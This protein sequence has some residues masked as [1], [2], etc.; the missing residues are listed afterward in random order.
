MLSGKKV[1]ITGATGQI[2]RPI[3]ERLVADNEVWCAARFSD[4]ALRTQLEGAGIKTCTW[5]LSSGD[6]SEI[7]ADF[8]H[9]LHAAYLVAEAQHDVAVRVNAESTG[10]LMQH[11]RRAQ[12]FVFVSASAVYEPQEPGHLY[13]ETDP[14]GGLA[15][16][17][18]SYPVSKIATEGVVHA[19]ARMFNLPS[20]IARMNIGYG[21]ASHGGVPVMFCQQILAGQPIGVPFGYESW[22]S[23][24]SEVDI[25][26]QASGPLFDVASVPVTVLN[27]AGDDA[28]THRELCEYIGELTGIAPQ[29]VESEFIFDSFASDNTQRRKLIGGCK[30]GWRDGVRSTLARHFPEAVSA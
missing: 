17:M 12:A 1:L 13:A 11:C 29:Y 23:P 2:G 6:L 15:S 5:S 24:I 3:A 8:T 4:P 20:T 30:V 22:G 9:V 25:A 19:A 7:P 21:M 28:V 16:Y 26:E 18:P 14:L 10:L 27:W